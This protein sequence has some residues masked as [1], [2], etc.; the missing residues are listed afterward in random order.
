M[1]STS[2]EIDNA[3]IDNS[4]KHDGRCQRLIEDMTRNVLIDMNTLKEICQNRY[5]TPEEKLDMTKA[6]YLGA[7]FLGE[8]EHLHLSEMGDDSQQIRDHWRRFYSDSMWT[9]SNRDFKPLRKLYAELCVYLAQTLEHLER[10][11]IQVVNAKILGNKGAQ[12]KSGI[13]KK[14]SKIDG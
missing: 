7:H 9:I 3:S 1:A 12:N 14:C 5:E 8:N 4:S 10:R 6:I 11:N 2:N 13:V